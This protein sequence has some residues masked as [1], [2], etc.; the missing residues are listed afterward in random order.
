MASTYTTNLG[1]EKIGTGEQDGTWGDTTNTNFDL[2]DQACNGME[3][4]TLT[5]GGTTGSP[6]ILPITDG[7]AS[8]GRNAFVTFDDTSNLGGNAFIQL[9]P[10]TAKKIVY[11]R[12]ALQGGR[13]LKLFQGTYTSS[14]RQLT[15]KNGE[16][17]CAFFDGTGDTTAKARNMFND[18]PVDALSVGNGLQID[19]TSISNSSDTV[20]IR[21]THSATNQVGIQLGAKDTHT[22]TQRYPVRAMSGGEIGAGFNGGAVAELWGTDSA[23]AE[24]KRLNTSSWGLDINGKMLVRPLSTSANSGFVA[25]D[26][27]AYT[28]C[29]TP[30]G[31]QSFTSSLGV[32][33]GGINVEVGEEPVFASA[34]DVRLKENIVSV[35]PAESMALIE[36]VRVCD[37]DVYQ[38]IWNRETTPPIATGVRGVIAQEYMV[39]YPH[40]V[41]P[42]A[43]EQPDSLLEVGQ[44]HTWDLLNAVKFLKSETDELREEVAWLKDQ[45]TNL[46]I[47]TPP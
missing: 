43:P 26:Q 46:L 32:G 2:L 6:N 33:L 21:S 20:S 31:V 41:R 30:T 17:I 27:G 18:L 14:S 40:G 13:N 36:Q 25:F 38:H 3:T 45:L 9:A 42:M 28:A 5:T 10:A 34:S 37:F 19:G 24:V 1:I 7:T 12:N 23:D 15:I 29:T 44:V 47:S 39:Q 22:N 35:D 16:T 4:I 8:S 11:I